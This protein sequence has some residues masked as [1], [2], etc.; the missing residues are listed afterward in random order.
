MLKLLIAVLSML[1]LCSCA[2]TRVLVTDCNDTA[3]PK[4]KD[5]ALVK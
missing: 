4:Y 3:N 2:A 1:V 5:C